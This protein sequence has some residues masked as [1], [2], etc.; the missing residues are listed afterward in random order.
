MTPEQVYEH[1]AKW[2]LSTT[3]SHQELQTLIDYEHTA[4]VRS[5]LIIGKAGAG[6]DTIGSILKEHYGHGTDSN[7]YTLKQVARV[8]F[9]SIQKD[10]HLLQSLSWFRDLVPSCYLDDAWR[11]ILYR[12]TLDAPVTVETV[13]ESPTDVL[14]WIKRRLFVASPNVTTADIEKILQR[15]YDVRFDDGK[16]WWSRFEPMVLEETLQPVQHV[17]LTDTRFP[18]EMV[19]GWGIGAGLIRVLCEEPIR[20][21]RLR[22]RDGHVDPERLHDASETALDHVF[23]DPEYLPVVS[24]VN[25]IDN[26]GSLEETR[27]QVLSLTI[28]RAA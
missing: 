13:F 10:R 28:E 20:I 23:T 27:Q 4:R 9:G 6:K 21:E 15:V 1:M 19:T 24:K 3:L 25:Y 5:F 12:R 11:R 16:P 7:A 18:N 8:A 17:V 14:L 22:L 2:G 26:N